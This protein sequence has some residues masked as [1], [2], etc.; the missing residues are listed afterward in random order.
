MSL[1]PIMAGM[2][3]LAPDSVSSRVPICEATSATP[4]TALISSALLSDMGPL[5]NSDPPWAL[6]VTLSE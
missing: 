5:E 2:P 6:T 3:K 1:P 4:G